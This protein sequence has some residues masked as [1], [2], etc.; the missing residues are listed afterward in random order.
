MVDVLWM[1]VLHGDDAHTRTSVDSML[2]SGYLE[3]T[4]D[5]TLGNNLTWVLCPMTMDLWNMEHVMQ[6]H[7]VVDQRDGKGGKE[8]IL[9]YAES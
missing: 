8:C 3:S 4:V 9:V 1:D 5:V 2:A 7:V 6:Y